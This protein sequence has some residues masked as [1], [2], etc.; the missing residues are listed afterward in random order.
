MDDFGGH[1][2]LAGVTV[3]IIQVLK[4]SKWAPFVDEHTDLI[5]RLVG[6]G[7]AIVTGFGVHVLS[8]W[9]SSTHT[10]T[11]TVGGLDPDMM[12][13]G[14]TGTITA[15]VWQQLLYYGFVKGKA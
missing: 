11:L 3:W 5:N 8:V 10:F 2:T 12:I 9:N 1:I 4:R 13:D 15:F 6:A 7:A 14:I